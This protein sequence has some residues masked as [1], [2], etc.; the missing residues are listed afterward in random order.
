MNK[1]FWYFL[2]LLLFIFKIGLSE[3]QLVG[4][5]GGKIVVGLN[6]PKFQLNDP[7]SY[8]KE[9]LFLLFDSLIYIDPI[10]F[11]IE[12]QLA[13]SWKIS[14]DGREWIFYLRKDLRWGDGNPLTIDDIILSL[15]YNNNFKIE[16]INDLTIKI[17]FQSPF[18]PIYYSLPPIIPKHLLEKDFEKKIIFG[19]GPF[20]LEKYSADE[21]IVFKR[22]PYYWKKDSKG[23]RLPYLDELIIKP[24][25]SLSEDLE[26][27]E[28]SPKDFDKMKNLE[29]YIIY[30][31]GPSLESDILLINQNPNSSI[32]KYK[33]KWFQNI[34]FRRAIA[35]AI[36]KELINKEI[37]FG[38]A[39]QILSPITPISPYYTPNVFRY[40][41]DLEKSK[42][43]LEDMGF[44]DRNGDGILE[45]IFKNILEINV[46]VEDIEESKKIIKILEEDFKK[47]GIK[48]NI[49]QKN[50]ISLKLFQSFHWEFILLKY[51]WNFN[52]LND[53]NIYLSKG[54]LHFWYPFQ[55]KPFYSWEEEIDIL[56]NKLY[57]VKSIAEK[58]LIFYNIQRIWTKNLPSI[59]I[60]N[61]FLIY[62][63]KENIR[64]FKPSLYSGPLWNSYEIFINSKI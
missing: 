47:I 51:K 6:I 20:I 16:K 13:K 44:K 63:G 36:N 56:F 32:P 43:L 37:Y 52:P 8:P 14:K 62:I 30:N 58:K 18:Y 21:E 39:H 10:N 25:F 29:K 12:P 49:I 31:L 17:I 28:L 2:I 61:P 59:I 48:L 35:H 24:K 64:N 23:N 34:K 33:L 60:S 38:F 1:K 11:K 41:Y 19:T 5:F 50:S 7:K 3:Y 42:K 26:I 46:L 22:N 54:S 53:S 57:E 40:D 4:N 55:R 45:D 9:I 27:M 15:T